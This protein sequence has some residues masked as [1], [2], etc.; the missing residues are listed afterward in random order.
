MSTHTSKRVL[1]VCGGRGQTFN[2]EFHNRTAGICQHPAEL[3]WL[4]AMN[5]YCSYTVSMQI[6]WSYNMVSHR[7]ALHAGDVQHGVEIGFHPSG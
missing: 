2:I 6:S 1:C 3:F 4:K 7:L 5:T